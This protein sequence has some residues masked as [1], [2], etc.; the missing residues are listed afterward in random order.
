[1]YVP[2]SYPVMLILLG[3]MTL[4]LAQS[5]SP[6]ILF[7]M[8][9]HRTL[10]W[11]T[12]LEGAANVILSILLVRKFGII[13]D[14][15]GTAIPLSLTVI[16]FLPRYLCRTLGVPMWTFVRQAYLL[17]LGLCVPLVASLLAMRSWYTPHNYPSL[18]LQL[19]LA[20]M[21]Y[22]VGLAW[23]VWTHRVWKVGELTP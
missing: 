12:S 5:A 18:A 2:L 22:G 19:A 3:P 16:Y 8:A 13:G 1:K 23:A 10:A 9:R 11:V 4:L 14:A 17:P 6:R 15:F 20:S 7:G 21:V